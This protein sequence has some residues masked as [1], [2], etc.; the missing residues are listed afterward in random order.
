MEKEAEITVLKNISNSEL[1]E[2]VLTHPTVEKFLNG[3]TPKRSLL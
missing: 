3:F 2:K 1:E